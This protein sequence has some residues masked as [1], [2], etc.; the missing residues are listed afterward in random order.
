MDILVAP[1][2]ILSNNNTELI[3]NLKVE[4]DSL[5]SLRGFSSLARTSSDRLM[6]S[7]YLTHIHISFEGFSVCFPL[8]LRLNGTFIVRLLFEKGKLIQK[9]NET[10][11]NKENNQK[12]PNKQ[13]EN[14]ENK[15]Q[16]Q[17]KND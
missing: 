1:Y 17:R 16:N 2:L 12:K 8:N 14:K 5:R 10:K 13:K 9:R 3:P 4:V 6:K 11:K 7:I 15:N